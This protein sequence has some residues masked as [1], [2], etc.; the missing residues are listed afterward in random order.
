MVNS[1]PGVTVRPVVGQLCEHILK[2]IN[3]MRRF[4]Y[5]EVSLSALL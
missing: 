2:G 5:H 4:L 3:V 1:H